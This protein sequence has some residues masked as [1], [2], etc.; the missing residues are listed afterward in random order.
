LVK[1]LKFFDADQGSGM[2]KIWIWNPGWKNSDPQHNSFNANNPYLR[3]FHQLMPPF[4][5]HRWRQR[6]VQ[7]HRL[8]TASHRRRETN[9]PLASSP[10]PREVQKYNQN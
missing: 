8:P 10:C 2:E 9:P 3:L 6:Q 7:I 4:Y 5:R 1:I